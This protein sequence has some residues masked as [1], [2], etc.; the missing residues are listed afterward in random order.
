MSAYQQTI[1]ED[2]ARAGMIGVD[3]GH[4]EACMRQEHPTLD[5][6]SREEFRREVIVGAECA[7]QMGAEACARLAWMEGCGPKPEVAR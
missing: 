1:R 6:L 7:R 3:P 4:V 5:S 2:L